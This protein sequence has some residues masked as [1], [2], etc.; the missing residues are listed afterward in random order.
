MDKQ[1][2]NPS[3]PCSGLCDPRD[4]VTNTQSREREQT[5]AEKDQ[6]TQ[7]GGQ[8]QR[9]A[10]ETQRN[11][12]HWTDLKHRRSHSEPPD[13]ASLVVQ[14]LRLHVAVQGTPVQSLLRED[15]TCG[16]A[17]TSMPRSGE[18][19]FWS[20]CSATREATAMSSREPGR[21]KAR[22]RPQSPSGPR[23]IRSKQVYICIL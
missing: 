15:P 20:L 18:P 22:E 11:E 19:V 2:E 14:R 1:H 23:M 6:E 16:G 21:E 12:R 10:L 4:I 3:L 5:E 13:G 8:T 9:L 7:R 17:A